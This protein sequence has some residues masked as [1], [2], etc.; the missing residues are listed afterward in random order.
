MK[1][2]IRT[3]CS[4]SRYLTLR[5]TTISLGWIKKF[6]E[7]IPKGSSPCPAVLAVNSREHSEMEKVTKRSTLHESTKTYLAQKIIFLRL[8]TTPAFP[9]L[10]K[11]AARS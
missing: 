3:W 7:N 4:L 10:K 2:V 11:C 1:R 8:C 9:E 5:G 6:S